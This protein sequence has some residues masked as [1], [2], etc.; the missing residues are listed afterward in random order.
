MEPRFYLQRV[1]EGKVA[2]NRI[3]L[4]I[5]S[6]DSTPAGFSQ[7]VSIPVHLRS[8]HDRDDQSRS[9][10]GGHRIEPGHL[11]AREQPG[12][13]S[14]AS[15]GPKP[16]AITNYFLMSSLDDD[17]TW[18]RLSMAAPPA[19]HRGPRAAITDDSGPARAG[20]TQVALW[21]GRG[22]VSEA[23]GPALIAISDTG[24]RVDR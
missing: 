12:N 3:H 5:C 8:G 13:L 18:T 24:E 19:G 6:S 21:R 9:D 11:P 23:V 10:T 2:K 16:A 22:T 15:S 20:K 17:L 14:P 1:P 7:A 4:D